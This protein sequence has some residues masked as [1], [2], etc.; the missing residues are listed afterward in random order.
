MSE[1]DNPEFNKWLD[2]FVSSMAHHIGMSQSVNYF[3][4][5][6]EE[7]KYL[8]DSKRSIG[9]CIHYELMTVWPGKET[10]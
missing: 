9:D 3:D 6:R 1:L 4:R 8:F 10:N 7:A 5:D 2:V